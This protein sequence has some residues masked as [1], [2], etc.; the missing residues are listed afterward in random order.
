LLGMFDVPSDF[1]AA[2]QGLLLLVIRPRRRA[3]SG[4]SE[5]E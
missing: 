2:V 1:T 4:R 3:V 5:D